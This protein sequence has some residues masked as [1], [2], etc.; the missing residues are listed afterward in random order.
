MPRCASRSKERNKERRE[1]KQ[2]SLSLHGVF[3]LVWEVSKIKKII[4][5]FDPLKCCE[6]TSQGNNVIRQDKIIVVGGEGT[7][8]GWTI[9]ERLSEEVY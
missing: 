6:G 2:A 8:L 3:M 7:A 4:L 5:N 1:T 9:R